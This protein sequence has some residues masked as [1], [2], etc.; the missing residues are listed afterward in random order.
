M[1]AAWLIVGLLPMV[2]S[3]TTLTSGS[4]TGPGIFSSAMCSADQ[5]VKKSGTG[6]T[7]WICA[8]DG[9]GG[10]GGAPTTS[11]YVT[12]QDDA[13]LSAD[14]FPSAAD[15]VVVT[16]TSTAGSWVTLP[17]SDAVT[18]KL[19]Y[20]VTTHAFSSGT[21]DDVPE[22]GDFSAL[23][24]G[25]GIVNT[26]GT[27]SVDYTETTCTAPLSCAAATTITTTMAS[28]R[29]IGRTTGGAG[30]ME[31]L[32]PDATLSLAAGNVGVVDVTCTGCLGA[33]EIAALD[34]GDIT[35]GVFVDARV[36]GSL[37]ADE[38]NPTLGTQTQGN[39]ALGDAEGGAA[40]TGDSA[41]AFFATGV[42]EV[43]RGGSGAVPTG[44]DYVLVADSI[45][46]ATWRQIP[47]C[48]ESGTLNY[49]Q[50]TNLFSCLTDSGGGG[51]GNSVEVSMA[52]TT[53]GAFFSTTVTG[54]AWVAAGSEIVCEPLGT[55]DDGLT[56]EAVAIAGL[57]ATA[58]NRV[59]GTGFDLMVH[60]PYGLEGTVRFH[61]LG[62]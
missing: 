22:V 46:A 54:Q 58:A 26:A 17:D 50:S 40:T 61:C 27:L 44:D 56:P 32:T 62:V 49:T 60:S 6:G 34:A 7:T 12:T 55:V 39:Y 8:A 31:S 2:A 23:L 25:V 37:E 47:D 41:L 48:G 51:G 10:G 42:L 5:I 19:Q 13:G 57:R 52:L 1:K 20:D 43:I 45:S 15:Q 11:E 36:D 29:L 53:D 33:T 16:S 59:V 24:G 4:I 38:V 3:A 14:V 21:D 30:V 35:T 18:Q 28:N 9:G